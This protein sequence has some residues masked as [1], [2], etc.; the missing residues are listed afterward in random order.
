MIM[1]YEYGLIQPTGGE[2]AVSEQ[3]YLS[4]QYYNKLVELE[5]E[6]R[7]AVL[8]AQLQFPHIAA[9]QEEYDQANNLVNAL[10][11]PSWQKP[12]AR[13][14]ESLER[15]KRRTPVPDLGKSAAV[16]IAVGVLASRHAAQTLAIGRP[17][18]WHAVCSRPPLSD[19]DERGGVARG[20]QSATEPRRASETEPRAHL[21]HP[22]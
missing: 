15:P 19:G 22:G 10:M 21:D 11:N 12:R 9:A 18:P 17:T 13:A 5:H 8:E 14:R 4:H 16:E 3:I 20:R 1:V 7:K 2:D 6:R